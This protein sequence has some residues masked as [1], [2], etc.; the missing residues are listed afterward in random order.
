MFSLRQLIG[1]CSKVTKNIDVLH[2]L[3]IEYGS[4]CLVSFYSGP[5]AFILATPLL[6][7]ILTTEGKELCG[8]KKLPSRPHFVMWIYPQEP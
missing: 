5:L 6:R 1:Y 8:E 4:I 3:L 7:K 2:L